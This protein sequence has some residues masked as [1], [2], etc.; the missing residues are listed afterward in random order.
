MERSREILAR[1]LA[2]PARRLP[3]PRCRT[4]AYILAGG[5]VRDLRRPQ[6]GAAT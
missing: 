5:D 4:L 6:G 2:N 3:A 1:I